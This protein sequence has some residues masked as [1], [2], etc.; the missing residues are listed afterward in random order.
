MP[1]PDLKDDTFQLQTS[2]LVVHASEKQFWHVLYNYFMEADD[3]FGNQSQSYL[4]VHHLTLATWCFDFQ[5]KQ[6]FF[7]FWSYLSIEDALFICTMNYVLAQIYKCGSIV[8][9][10]QLNDAKLTT[11]FLYIMNHVPSQMYQCC[12]AKLPK[13][14]IS[15]TIGA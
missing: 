10:R 7:L 11:Q 3:L 8:N 2:L 14:L 6:R 4:M 15:S 13:Q 12:L 5:Q 1:A 9:P